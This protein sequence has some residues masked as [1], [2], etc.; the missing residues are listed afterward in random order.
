MYSSGF[1]FWSWVTLPTF[2][3]VYMWRILFSYFL[4]KRHVRYSASSFASFS[5]VT[6]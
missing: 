1:F 4:D 5:L 6:G 2:V 3:G